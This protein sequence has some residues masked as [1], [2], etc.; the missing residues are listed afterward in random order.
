MASSMKSVATKAG[1]N[2]ENIALAKLAKVTLPKE[3]APKG[4]MKSGVNQGVGGTL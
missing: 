4:Q 1:K 2:A 3:Y